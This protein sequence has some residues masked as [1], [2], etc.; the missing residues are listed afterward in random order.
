MDE[1][2]FTQAGLFAVEV[3]LLRLLG[4]WGVEPDVVMGHSIGE[5]TAAFAAGVLSLGDAC[6]V[7]AAR[8]RL[9]QALEPG[10]VM[11]AV[12]AAEEE[13]RPFLTGGVDLAAVNGPVSV[14]LSGDEVPV[15]AA[16]EVLR[17][18]GCRVRRLVVSHA[19]HSARMEPMLAEFVALLAGVSWG[20]AR[21]P[22]VSNVT[23][24]VAE[25]RLLSSSDYWAA[26][27]RR[28]VRFHDGVGASGGEVF[29]EVGPGA[30]LSG[31]LAE[32]APVV[33][34]LR[35]DRSEVVTVLTAAAELFVRGR[36]VDWAATLPAGS[37]GDGVDLPTYA[38]DHRHYWLAMA[39]H[40]DP[41]A[42]GQ[43]D[44]DHPLLGALVSRPDGGLVFTSRLSLR[45]DPWL[46]DHAVGG[47]VLVAGTGLVELAVR[48]GDEAGAPLVRELVIEA[49]LV[50][51]DRGGLR[52]Q[53]GVSAVGADATRTVEIH[54]ALEDGS[55]WTRHA[56]GILAPPAPAP[57]PV[58]AL[59]LAWPPP[60]AEPVPLDPR[61]FYAD[62]AERGYAYGPAFQGLRAAWRD[63][64]SI[65]AEVELPAAERETATRFA[66]HPA[67]LD[68]ALH[69]NGLRPRPDRA[70]GEDPEP[71]SP[72]TVLPFAWT[73][74]SL[75]A[76]GADALRVRV[77]PAGPD[78]PDTVRLDAT[79]GTGALVLT[80]DA[81]VFRPVSEAQLAAAPAGDA[82][83]RVDWVALVEPTGEP[84]PASGVTVVETESQDALTATTDT[85]A[86]LQTWLEA[87]AGAAASRSAEPVDS[88]LV[89]VTR[90]GVPAGDT[91]APETAAAAVWGLVRAAQAEHPG[92]V[93]LL[94][95][96]EGSSAAVLGRALATG[97]PQV[98]V[99]GGALLAPRLARVPAT[100]DAAPITVRQ[101]GTVLVTGGTGAL[102]RLV[103]EHLVTR[104]GVRHLLLVG[105]RGQAAPGIGASV[106]RLRELGADVEVRACDVSDAD[107]LAAVVGGIDPAHPLRGIVHAAGVLD[108]GVVTA[109]TPERVAG[110]F[111][112]KVRAAEHLAR[113]ADGLAA[114]AQ[115]D[116]DLFVLFSSAS[117]VLGSPG[118]GNYAAANAYLDALA[119]RRRAAGHTATSLSWGPWQQDGAMTDGMR[120]RDRASAH[121][122]I[123]PL[124]PDQGL[125][126]F[127][128]ALATARP[129][130]VPI[131]LDLRVLRAQPGPAAPPLLRELVPPGRRGARGGSD[132]PR[133]LV[134]RL[135][136][137]ADPQRDEL[138]LGVVRA[139][140]AAVLGLSGP[141]DVE[142]ETAFKE[143]G[144]DSLT[145]VEL[146][147]RLREA[148]G[149]TLPA[150]V[151]FD[152]PTPLALSRHLLERLAP[153]G[154][155]P[156]Q[157][158]LETD[159][160]VLR[161]ALASLPLERFRQAGLLDALLR[162][163][164]TTSVEPAAA[165]E[166]EAL[167]IAEL[168]VDDLVRLALGREGSSE[169]RSTWTEGG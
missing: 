89:V 91:A 120:H 9:M 127:D 63:G 83:Y 109:L 168:N 40:S 94:D 3:A 56:T 12:N 37:V 132:D 42:V 136:G 28:P 144:F 124:T 134:R 23:G 86:A 27:V 17:A 71:G 53:V 167:P 105:R 11:V 76:T 39:R 122:G 57:V 118:Q 128:R 138:L 152:H 70:G 7:V 160:A 135:S 65:Y 64:E 126:L 1:T 80:A 169:P 8:G 58:P 145:S 61:G 18:R 92:Q 24:A 162:L 84:R 72:T 2:V 141:Q 102:G 73:G 51:P 90:S 88:R 82:L 55:A 77:T 147:N 69:T 115:G 75:L 66:L 15:L 101:G 38:F 164:R 46:A 107:A 146:R 151:V 111:A 32:A 31:V 110:V 113:L 33:A 6:T 133:D 79:D 13:V 129:Q 49:P 22:V 159:E 29:V 137:L 156:G 30:A 119:H 148:T 60:G 108:D 143:A 41:V 25:P 20:S 96:D 161:S 19:F 47:V 5:V 44:V 166:P 35:D 165:T 62:L 100:A 117:G 34:A 150:T 16:A 93:V 4:S 78:R 155:A 36:E 68:A 26:H 54:S 142:P 112:A 114:G 67:L 97:E 149:L 87:Q 140:V 158:T 116:L 74:V 123:L 163:A 81:I 14:V 99:R 48:A 104:H 50:V 103:A 139:R 130:L 95:V 125:A 131:R 98:A 52:V 154:P 85:L 45:T 106:A 10:G 21:I 153:A 43:A 157:P 121:L 59:A